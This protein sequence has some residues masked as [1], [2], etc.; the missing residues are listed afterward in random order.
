MNECHELA[1]L[2]GAAMPSMH[3]AHNFKGGFI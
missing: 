3:V 1:C 2:V